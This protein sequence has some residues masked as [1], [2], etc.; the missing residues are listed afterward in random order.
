MKLGS[1]IYT[2]PQSREESLS[3]CPRLWFAVESYPFPPL[4]SSSAPPKYTPSEPHLGSNAGICLFNH[5][6]LQK[7]KH[8]IIDLL[9]IIHVSNYIG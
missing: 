6:L 1:V 9:F 3:P 2:A 4:G 8:C 5:K 7:K